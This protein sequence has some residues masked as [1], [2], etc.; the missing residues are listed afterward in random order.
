MTDFQSCTVRPQ[1]VFLVQSESEHE[2]YV[3]RIKRQEKKGLR[4]LASLQ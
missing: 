2:Y 4:L 1:L 3:A